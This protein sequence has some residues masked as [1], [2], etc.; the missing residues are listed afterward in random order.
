VDI[1]KAKADGDNHIIIPIQK[2]VA[3]KANIDLTE[4]INVWLW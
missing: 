2:K 4:Q 1:A 3:T